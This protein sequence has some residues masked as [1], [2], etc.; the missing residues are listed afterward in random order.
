MKQKKLKLTSQK[1]K[2]SWETIIKLYANKMNNLKEMDTFLKRYNLPR[3][4]QEE[5][6]NMNRSIT[7]KQTKSVIS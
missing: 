6:E 1:Y 3:L 2:D 5:R 4:N 7:S